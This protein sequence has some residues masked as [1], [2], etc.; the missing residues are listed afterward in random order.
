MYNAAFVSLST[1]PYMA[2]VHI[3]VHFHSVNV[4]LIDVIHTENLNG[5]TICIA[6]DNCTYRMLPTL[7]S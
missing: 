3:Y 6:D 4:I 7:F 1:R 2:K 5:Y